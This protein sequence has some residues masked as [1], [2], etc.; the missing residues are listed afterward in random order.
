MAESI[1]WKTELRKYERQFDGLP[2]EP[3][4]EEVRAQRL[5]FAAQREREARDG[6]AFAAWMRLLLV[7]ALAA[8]LPLWPYARDCGTGLAFYL[9]ATAAIAIG[10]TWVAIYGWCH[11]LGRAHTVAL[12]TALWGLGLIASEVLPR[13]GYARVSAAHPA[14]WR[15][16]GSS[17]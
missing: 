9:M 8:A 1:D 16:S 4:P 2:P 5:A 6:A 14:A 7:V 3:T 15:C 12:L 13:V 11:R 17:R 10:G